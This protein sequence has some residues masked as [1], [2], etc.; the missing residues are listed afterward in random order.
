M[1]SWFDQQETTN[2]YTK[3]NFQFEKTQ[4]GKYGCQMPVI[5]NRQTRHTLKPL[6]KAH[7]TILDR[8]AYHVNVK[9]QYS[10]S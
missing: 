4:K 9:I 7:H 10:S 1:V 6:L 3:N 8:N 2:F 5:R